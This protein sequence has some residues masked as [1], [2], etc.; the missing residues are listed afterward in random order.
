MMVRATEEGTAFTVEVD[1]KQYLITAKHIVSALPEGAASNI[2]ILKKSGWR[3]LRVRVFKCG[4]PVDIAVLIPDAQLTVT[5]PLEPSSKGMASGQDAYFVGFPYH[6][7]MTYKSLPDVMGF[8]RRATVSAFQSFPDRGYQIIFLDAVN[9]PGFSGSPVV[10]RDLSRPDVVFKVAGVVT[11]FIPDAVP[12]LKKKKELRA[13]E[14]TPEDQKTDQ[15]VNLNTGL[16]KA[17]DIG[18]AI[19]LIE[20]HPLGPTVDDNFT[21]EEP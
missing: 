17:W 16:A 21:G 1:R 15:L 8:V 12:V 20:K 2:K 18:T 10:Y 4:E 9:N 6:T 19:A 7:A 11:A 13:E 14:V 5:Y 3:D